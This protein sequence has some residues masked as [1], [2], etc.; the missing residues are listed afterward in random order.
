MLQAVVS[1]DRD[2]FVGTMFNLCWEGCPQHGFLPLPENTLT[3]PW[4][5]RSCKILLS[6]V[7]EGAAEGP[8]ECTHVHMHSIC[9]YNCLFISS[10]VGSAL[11]VARLG[12]ES[13]GGR[14]RKGQRFRDD[15]FSRNDFSRSQRS[16]A[17]IREHQHMTRR[18]PNVSRDCEQVEQAFPKETDVVGNLPFETWSSPVF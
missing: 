4:C 16:Q 8:S 14:T 5:R 12:Q 7:I 13:Y 17:V 10:L 18:I 9:A 15:Y 1:K 2:G 6:K 3:L 11:W